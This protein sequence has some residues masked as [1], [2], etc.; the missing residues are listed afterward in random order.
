MESLSLIVFIGTFRRHTLW[1]LSSLRVSFSYHPGV[2]LLGKACEKRW[3]WLETIDESSTTFTFAFFYLKRKRYNIIENEN[4]IGNVVISETKIYSREHIENDQ[5][6]LKWYLEKWD[7]YA[8]KIFI[9]WIVGEICKSTVSHQ[10]N[11]RLQVTVVIFQHR[12]VV[13]HP[14]Q[15]I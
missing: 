10:Y 15:D 2:D 6:P 12:C 9:C 3:K 11:A 13:S 8:I 5:N 1:S 14:G 4:G 7:K